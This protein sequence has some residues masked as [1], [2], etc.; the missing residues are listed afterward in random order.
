MKKAFLSLGALLVF[1]IASAQTDPQQTQTQ[2]QTQPKTKTTTQQNDKTEVKGAV[3]N[4]VKKTG[5]DGEMVQPRKDELKTRDH[6]KSTPETTTKTD[7]ASSRQMSRTKKNKK[8]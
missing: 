8:S 7:T 4:D 5:A 3:V 6:V 2:T 1:G